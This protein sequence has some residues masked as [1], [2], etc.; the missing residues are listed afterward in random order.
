MGFRK[1]KGIHVKCY[2]ILLFKVHT[3]RK[4]GKR[5]SLLQTHESSSVRK[6]VF[7]ERLSLVCTTEEYVLRSC[8]ATDLLTRGTTVRQKRRH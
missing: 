7:L 8:I 1:W 6:I 2:I 3:G 4:E 5:D